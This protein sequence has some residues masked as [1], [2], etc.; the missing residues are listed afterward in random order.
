[1]AG[2]T[3]VAAPQAV[4]AGAAHVA[5]PQGTNNHLWSTGNGPTD[6]GVPLM[7]GISPSLAVL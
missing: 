2:V 5:V 1:M 4:G 6:L 7:P 3:L